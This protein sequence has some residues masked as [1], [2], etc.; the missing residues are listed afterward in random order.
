VQ[1]KK[2]LCYRPLPPKSPN[3]PQR[4]GRGHCSGGP[5]FNGRGT[6]RE[7]P[8]RDPES[9]KYETVGYKSASEASE[10]GREPETAVP[11][12]NGV[13]VDGEQLEPASVDSGEKAA[14]RGLHEPDAKGPPEPF[15]R[16]AAAATETAG[17]LFRGRL[18]ANFVAIAVGR[19]A[20][21]T[22]AGSSSS[23]YCCNRSPFIEDTRPAAELPVSGRDDD[24]RRGGE[25]LGDVATTPGTEPTCT[26]CRAFHCEE[27]ASKARDSTRQELEAWCGD[28]LVAME[29]TLLQAHRGSSKSRLRPAPNAAPAEANGAEELLLPWV[30]LLV[31]QWALAEAGPILA[32]S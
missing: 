26:A 27:S 29:D 30:A 32:L 4:G 16:A 7:R 19:G 31:R 8:Q 23:A 22:N 15:A 1:A 24:R 5:R 14:A 2:T 28:M 10:E 25:R 6:Q 11:A 12:D 17:K 21:T 3:G 20:W 13:N 9:E 18:G